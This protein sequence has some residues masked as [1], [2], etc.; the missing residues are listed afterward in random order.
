MSAHTAY[1]QVPSYT[2]PAAIP[3]RWRPP[4]QGPPPMP[5]GMKVN[6]QLWQAGRWQFNH[7]F[8]ATQQQGRP[9]HQQ[10]QH[11]WTASQAWQQSRSQDNASKNPYKRTTKPP[12]AEYL[13]TS[14]SDNPLGLT[15]MIP[16]EEYYAQQHVPDT[17]N[18]IH[19]NGTA[20]TE[21]PWIW[22]PPSLAPDEDDATEPSSNSSTHDS[23]RPRTPSRTASGSSQ[24]DSAT[25][26]QP[27]NPNTE[28]R[29]EEN[30]FTAKRELVPTF[31]VNIIRTPEHYK[32]S[33]SRS[34]SRSSQHTTRSSRGSIDSQHLASRMESLS[35]SDFPSSQ[36]QQ[37]I[38]PDAANPLEFAQTVTGVQNLVEEPATSLLS[39]L[40]LTTPKP[41]NRSLGRFSTFP[42]I[43]GPA[44]LHT[45]PEGPVAS[46]SSTP[47]QHS[48][49]G[50]KSSSR[51]PS[52]VKTDPVDSHHR[53]HSPNSPYF[54]PSPSRS[55]RSSSSSRG[56]SQQP[57]P[58]T[59]LSL[60]PNE[61]HTSPPTSGSS[62]HS[63]P[64]P[65][66]PMEYPNHSGNKVT[67]RSSIR[68]RKG[69]WNKRGDHYT[70]SGY[71]VYAP[72]DQAFPPELLDY[73]DES[74]GYLD[75][76]GHR[77]NPN[78]R[79]ELPD[80][81]PRHGQP[82]LRPYDSFLEYV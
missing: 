71:V 10:P 32:S 70:K 37:F 29:K 12:S 46:T 22:N 54:N 48:L 82:P 56:S 21:S 41:Q 67:T 13:A 24:R 68:V 45:I 42:L 26:Q 62:R 9:S 53:N 47:E 80:S 30:P 69:F 3:Q 39:P 79:P 64:L 78:Q 65:V 2:Q 11:A 25:S 57:S 58:A 1:Y 73:P 55:S 16:A 74:Q 51:L 59:S 20:V 18:D 40:M 15:D 38:P 7:A 52:R 76:N 35:T 61:Y 44:S 36:P 43:N 6:P 34:S 28:E 77:V 19:R 50:H 72:H 31:S 63:N 60:S 49:R 81:I 27:S 4:F 23:N 14:L 33:P 17:V 5:S 75:E 8:Y 66:P